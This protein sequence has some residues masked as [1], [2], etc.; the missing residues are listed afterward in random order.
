MRI[1][2]SIAALAWLTFSPACAANL[3]LS[4][5]YH[6]VEAELAALGERPVLAWIEP[7]GFV[8]VMF[9]EPDAGLNGTWTLVVVDPDRAIATTYRNGTGVWTGA[10]AAK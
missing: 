4:G 7:D 5:D 1:S 3:S 9:A 8:R 2:A 10:F 6:V